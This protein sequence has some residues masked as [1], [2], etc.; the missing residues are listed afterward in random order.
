M[1]SESA[2][3]GREGEPFSF[4]SAEA[5]L[6]FAPSF[7]RA[8]RLVCVKVACQSTELPVIGKI[9]ISDIFM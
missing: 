7:P 8:L 2:A 1:L 6:M 4:F 3:L 9:A 5:P